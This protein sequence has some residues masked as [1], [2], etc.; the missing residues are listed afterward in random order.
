MLEAATRL[1]AYAVNPRC[2]LVTPDL[3]IAAHA[4]G[5]KVL[6]W[7]VDRPEQMRALIEAG[8]DGIMTNYPDRMR[9]VLDA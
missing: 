6:V 2:D 4:R 5:F 7:T 3:C 8:V 1:H 9:S